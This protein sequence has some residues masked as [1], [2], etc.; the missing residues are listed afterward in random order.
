MSVM[1][2]QSTGTSTGKNTKLH[3]TRPLRGECTGG[4]GDPPVTGGSPHKGPVMGETLDH[5]MASASGVNLTLNMY[6]C[7]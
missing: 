3:N 2:A 6:H 1:A 5:V 7:A 4:E